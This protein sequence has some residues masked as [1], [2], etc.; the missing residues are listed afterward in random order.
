MKFATV[1]KEKID[2]TLENSF[3]HHGVKFKLFKKYGDLYSWLGDQTK[4]EII[5]CMGPN[6]FFMGDVDKLERLFRNTD[7]GIIFSSGTNS[8][9]DADFFIGF[10]GVLHEYFKTLMSKCIYSHKECIEKN[11]L[12]QKFKI[13]VDKKEK[14]F[15]KNVQGK[16]EMNAFLYHYTTGIPKAVALSLPFKVIENKSHTFENK[17]TILII[18]LFIVLVFFGFYRSKSTVYKEP[19]QLQ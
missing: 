4:C 16:T 11:D 13:A 7:K 14:L 19:Y 5:V 10:A 12:S 15:K 2:P 3:K 1:V 17:T 8:E 18:T 6:S 9:K